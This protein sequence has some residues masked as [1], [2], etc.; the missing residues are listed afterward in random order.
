MVPAGKK[1]IVL[2]VA[3]G[4]LIVPQAAQAEISDV[5]NGDVTCEVQEG[6]GDRFCGSDAP[7]STTKS[8]VDGVPIDVNVAFPPEPESGPDGGFP[9][10]MLFHGY[11]GSKI[12]FGSMQHW[13]DKG[14]ATF[15]MTDRGFGESCSS[16]GSK[17]ADPAGCQT[18]YIRLIDN[19]YEVRDAQDFAGELADEGDGLVDPQKIASVGGS[20]GGGMS[21]A[22]GALKDRVVNLDYSL[23]PWKSPDGKP[24]QIAAAAPNIP[25]TDLAYSLAPNGSTL[26]YVADAPYQGRPGVQKQGLVHGLY[27]SS[28]SNFLA[29]EGTDPTADQTG[30]IN[31]LDAGEPYG[32][33]VQDILTELTLHHSSYYIDHSEPPAPMLMSSGFTDDLF[34]ADETIRYYN[35]TKTEYPDADLA[36]F[37]GDFGHPRAQNKSDVSSALSDRID[38]WFDYYVKG[39]GEA[40]QQGAEAYT[41]TCP[42]GEPSGGP[43]HADSWAKLAPGEIR[44]DD[45]STKTIDAGSNSAGAFGVLDNACASTPDDDIN[46]A[47]TYE[48]DAAP[49]GGYTLMGA[50][51]VIADYAMA[52]GDENSQVAARLVDVAPDNTETLV[53]RGLWRPDSGDS[54]GQVFQLHPNGWK[55]EAGHVPKLELMAADGTPGGGDFDSYG[56]PSNGQ[57]DVDVSNLEMRMPVLEKPGALGGLVKAAAP[58]V[59]PDGYELAAEFA[60]LRSPNAKLDGK[61]LKVKGN[62]V[63]AKVTCPQA[64]EACHKGKL[65]LRATGKY[66]KKQLSFKVGS[67]KFD[68]A[69]GGATTTLK[70][71]LSKRA[72]KFLKHK[73]RKLSVEATLSISEVADPKVQSAKVIGK[74]HKKH[75]R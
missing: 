73:K 65:V 39:E 1:L 27:L 3:A 55:F 35:R 38:D 64:F 59:L 28:Q 47:A 13:L 52:S 68:Q 56:R 71:K 18:G 22:L 20:Y 24:M 34:P 45:A 4:A 30:W 69:D 41:L 40:P 17:A 36:L 31:T 54:Q 58:K 49:S 25:W 75:K 33:D 16:A 51:T 15:S 61:K 43:Y 66:K 6:S 46:G 44:F 5:F 67:A 63:V 74:K 10:V 2:A 29:P 23:A 53:D 57:Q 11:G 32:S 12:G 50:V 42:G 21:M 14:Y 9:L 72:K 26:D 8:P 62:K 37:F 70:P 48:L 7:R 19:R 60:A